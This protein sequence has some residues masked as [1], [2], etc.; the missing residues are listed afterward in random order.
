MAGT[1]RVREEPSLD[2]R[3]VG[4]LTS[5]DEF[6]V[7]GNFDFWGPVA[8]SGYVWYP[9]E[10]DD[11]VG[12]AAKGAG[13]GV[14]Y[15]EPVFLSL[16]DCPEASDLTA[17]L[18]T[19]GFDRVNCFGSEQ[20]TLRG[21]TEIA[22]QGGAREG[23]YEPGW[24]ASWCIHWVLTDRQ[25]A[26]GPRTGTLGLSFPPDVAVPDDVVNG[27]VV[28]VAGHFDDPAAAACNV[29][30]ETTYQSNDSSLW[31]LCRE[32]FVVTEIGVVGDIGLPAGV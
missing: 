12:W 28:E 25:M 19:P 32:Q 23:T 31:V 6:L 11:L 22:C 15:L 8:A 5:G 14:L 10:T 18:E 24:L 26:D 4:T 2:A 1:V 3:V 17:L 30:P 29:E 16:D 20:I 9:I 7:L 13:G 27:S 21:V